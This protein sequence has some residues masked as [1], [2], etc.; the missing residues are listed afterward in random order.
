L[1]R[2]FYPPPQ[3]SALSNQPLRL[4]VIPIK[5]QR[6]DSFCPATWLFFLK[7]IDHVQ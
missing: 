3:S 4:A 6:L 2:K 1:L 7:E 5:N